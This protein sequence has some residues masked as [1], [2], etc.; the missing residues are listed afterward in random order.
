MKAVQKN[1]QRHNN[2]LSKYACL[3]KEAIYLNEIKEDIRTP[4]FRDI[5]KIIYTLSFMRYAD[6]TQVF[7]FKDNDHITKRML[8]I[9]YVSK[10]ARTIG[11]ALGL[12]EDLIEAASL[13]HDL[14]HTPFG[15]V[16][17]A[18][19]NKISLEENLGYY[20][21]NIHS[22]RLL[23]E[24]ENYGEGKNITLQTLDAVMCH[25]GEFLKGMYQPRKKTKEQFLTE[26]HNSY[27]D[28][29]IIKNLIPMTLEGCVVRISDMVAYLGKD[30]EDA[31]RLKIIKP[32]IVPKK[33]VNVLGLNNKDIVNTITLDIIHNS[34]N[35][36]YLKLS[37]NIYEA[38]QELKKF[39]YENIYAKAYTKE[40]LI[41][42]EEGFR[43]LYQTYLNDL[44][45]NNLQSNI[46]ISYYNNMSAKYKE[47]KKEQIVI[48]YIAGMTD[49]YFKKEYNKI[50]KMNHN[51]KEVENDL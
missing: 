30:I 47:N 45:T 26:Y 15:H 6:K 36:P 32:S 18:I 24:I 16:G 49:D 51:S 17:E 31:I 22:V 2:G 28:K 44:K 46:V 34:I 39:N 48:D 14:G 11:R 10:I 5:D 29:N 4:F 42:I 33:I 50:K 9:Q 40:E 21:H 12:N 8:H 27:H 43:A 38:M 3:D 23:M 13:A 20:N 7:S 37:D 1:M 35:K 19:L 25:N 41:K